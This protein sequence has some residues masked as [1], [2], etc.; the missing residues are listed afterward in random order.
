MGSHLCQTSPK[1]PLRLLY[2]KSCFSRSNILIS[3]SSVL[4]LKSM[5]IIFYN[6]L[7]YYYH[8]LKSIFYSIIIILYHVLPY[9]YSKIALWLLDSAALHPQPQDDDG[10][11]APECSICLANLEPSSAVGQCSVGP[12][13]I[14]SSHRRTNDMFPKIYAQQYSSW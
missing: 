3:S 6:I 10:S 12:C 4:I 13:C 11:A 7:F 1:Y 2:P 8:I 9:Y 5:I 14:G